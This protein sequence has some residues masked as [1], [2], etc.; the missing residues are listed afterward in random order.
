MNIFTKIDSH[1]AENTY[2][3]NFK[4]TNDCIVI[5]PGFDV[6]NFIKQKVFNLK[7]ILLTHGHVDHIFFVDKLKS[8]YKEALI[9]AHVDEKNLLLDPALNLSNYTGTISI[10]ADVYFKQDDDIFG[11]KVIHTKGH[12]KGSSCFYSDKLK[13]LFTGDTL[14]LNSIGRTD[15]PTGTEDIVKSIKTKLFVLDDD[16]T[17]YPGHGDTT[18]I[19]DEKRYNSY[20]R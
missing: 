13:S 9:Y 16:V 1:T 6:S 5:D 2:I 4:N 10:K 11:L 17:V 7:A 8:E 18:Y 20:V 15:L 3:I 19:G 14:F 12:T